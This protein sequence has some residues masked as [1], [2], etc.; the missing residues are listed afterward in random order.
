MNKK[1]QLLSRDNSDNPKM[2][3]P[4]NIYMP[5]MAYFLLPPSHSLYFIKTKYIEKQFPG[6]KFVVNS[7]TT[8]ARHRKRTVLSLCNCVSKYRQ[9]TTS[10]NT[11]QTHT[12]TQSGKKSSTWNKNRYLMMRIIQLN[13]GGNNKI[14]EQ[15]K[16]N[17][18]NFSIA[19]C[20]CVCVFIVASVTPIKCINNRQLFYYRL[21][22]L[23]LL[24]YTSYELRVGQPFRLESIEFQYI[25]YI[26]K[27]NAVF[28]HI[29]RIEI[30]GQITTEIGMW[31]KTRKYSK[32]SLN[33]S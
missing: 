5:S 23:L 30:K 18:L 27:S 33:S 31:L 19:M 8:N 2:C 15:R 13:I 28:I 20:V 25:E 4:Y 3:A 14:V 7:S 32:N 16:S 6:N 1:H 24:M 26:V 17:K 9:Q 12:H 29:T 11:P 10:T 21:V 22:L